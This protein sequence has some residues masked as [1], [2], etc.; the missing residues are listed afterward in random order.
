MI[1]T[2]KLTGFTADSDDRPSLDA[3]LDLLLSSSLLE[4]D[5]IGDIP[6]L[7]QFRKAY[8]LAFY[9]F[10]QFPGHHSWLR[11]GRVTRMAYRIGLDRL[12]HIRTI[13]PDWSTVSDEEI[14]EWRFF[15]CSTTSICQTFN[16]H[17]DLKRPKNC[18]L[19]FAV[20]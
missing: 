2:A 13:Y 19:L 17:P 9:E 6:S 20:K 18:S 1:I 7:D 3:G 4:D 5:L 11:V 8:L 10:H 16:C 14:Q 15:K 12:D